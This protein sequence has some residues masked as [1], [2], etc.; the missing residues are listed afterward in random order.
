MTTL[1]DPTVGGKVRSIV[2]LVLAILGTVVVVLTNAPAA[3]W[4]PVVL[5]WLNALVS[6][7]THFTAIGNDT[8]AS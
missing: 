7:L 2:Y 5:G 4:T 1:L 8:D 6:G 3:S